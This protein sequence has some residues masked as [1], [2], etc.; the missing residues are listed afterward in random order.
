MGT[1]V[2]EDENGNKVEE[3]LLFAFEIGIIA[4][5]LANPC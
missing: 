4:M 2:V 3:D 1:V 5:L